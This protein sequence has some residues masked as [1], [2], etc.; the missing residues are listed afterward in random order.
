MN[1]LSKKTVFARE[2]PIIGITSAEGDSEAVAKRKPADAEG[3][4]GMCGAK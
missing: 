3:K 1:F 2:S 4:E